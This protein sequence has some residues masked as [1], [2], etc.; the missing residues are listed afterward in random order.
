ME[1]NELQP[2]ERL[3]VAGRAD[4]PESLRATLLSTVENARSQA[5]WRRRFAG[6]LGVLLLTSILAAGSLGYQKWRITHLIMSCNDQL[7]DF[8]QRE[9]NAEQEISEAKPARQSQR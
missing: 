4:P 7:G 6:A 5:Q 8:Y 1:R 3:L 2:I 9:S